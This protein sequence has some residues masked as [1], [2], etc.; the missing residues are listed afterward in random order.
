VKKRN[1]WTHVDEEKPVHSHS[2][3]A[4]SLLVFR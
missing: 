3:L 1:N 2:L 4:A